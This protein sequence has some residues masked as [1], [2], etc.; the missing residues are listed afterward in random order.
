MG[1][2][3]RFL[4]G[5]A[6]WAVWNYLL[7]S[8]P[9]VIGRPVTFHKWL[10][11]TFPY[12]VDSALVVSANV[13]VLVC[14]AYGCCWGNSIMHEKQYIAMRRPIGTNIAVRY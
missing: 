13:W 2:A 11:C 9:Q 1:C 12:V 6:V 8:L 7:Q 5:F 14:V 4:S 3:L 10:A